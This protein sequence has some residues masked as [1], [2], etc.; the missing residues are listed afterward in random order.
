MPQQI[1]EWTLIEEIGRGNMGIVH[2]ATH[3]YWN[4]DFAVK[5]IKPEMVNDKE[6]R[7]RFISEASLMGRLRHP[8]IIETHPPIEEANQVFLPMEFLRGKA[9]N[10]IMAENSHPWTPAKTINIIRQ[11][12]AAVGFAHQQD[13]K[14]LHRD[15]KP[16]NIFILDNGWVKVLDFGL[17]RAIGD[18]TRTEAGKAVGTPNYLAPEILK[19]QKAVPQSDVYALGLVFYKM[20]AGRLPFDL[21]EEDSSFWAIM[22]VVMQAH[23]RGFDSISKYAPDTP[24]WIVEII[25]SCLDENPENRPTDATVL[26]SMMKKRV[27]GV[28]D[29]NSR[30]AQNQDSSFKDVNLGGSHRKRSMG[31]QEAKVRSNIDPD[32]TFMNLNIDNTSDTSKKEENIE[33]KVEEERNEKKEALKIGSTGKSVLLSFGAFFLLS[34]FVIPFNVMV[35]F[36]YGGFDFLLGTIISAVL[37]FHSRKN[38]TAAIVFTAFGLLFPVSVIFNYFL[39]S[40]F[41]VALLGIPP[42]LG[43]ISGATILGHHVQKNTDLDKIARASFLAGLGGF[44]LSF[45]G[46]FAFFYPMF[47]LLFLAPVSLFFASLRWGVDVPTGILTFFIGSAFSMVAVFDLVRAGEYEFWV[48]LAIS[49]GLLGGGLGYFVGKKTGWQIGISL[50]I[51]IISY[52]LIGDL[53]YPVLICWTLVAVLGGIGYMRARSLERIPPTTAS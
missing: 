3:K 45:T 53:L 26:E 44:V 23:M 16:G 15:I 43:L 39:T 6:S 25:D 9:L 10:E 32:V 1:R 46:Y 35:G 52:F 42:F 33:K 14:I 8:N 27:P 41:P 7:E 22:A 31:D 2:R 49:F 40:T 19:G 36:F 50:P 4:G 48:A 38:G 51:S 28:S 17:A 30:T 13:P 20:L 34:W 37:F 21:P 11:T 29:E 47:F 18:K 24:N 12:A 5:A